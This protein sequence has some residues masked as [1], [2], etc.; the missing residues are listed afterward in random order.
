MLAHL[1]A[2][3]KPGARVAVAGARFASWWLTPLNLWVMFRA[4]HDL[5]IYAGLA[6]PWRNLLTCVPDLTARSRLFGTGY[7][8]HGRFR[9]PHA[10]DRAGD[11][12][13]AMG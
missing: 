10:A 13:R 6:Q 5:T 3:A 9:A 7:V 4:R 11:G 8:A 12:T 1:F 2:R